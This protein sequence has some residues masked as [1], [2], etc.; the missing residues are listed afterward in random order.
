MSDD[1]ALERLSK[2]INTPEGTGEVLRSEVSNR[3]PSAPREWGAPPTGASVKKRFRIT[4][5]EVVFGGSVVFFVGA[6]VFAFLL[7]F[8]GNNTV[9]TKNVDIAVSGPTEIGAGNTLDLQVVIT[10]RNTV[11][12]ELPDLIVEFPAGTRSDADV[13]V[14]LPRVRK[15]LSTIEPGQSVHETVRAVLFG[16]EGSEAIVK[17][18]VEYRVPA[19]NAIFFA[20]ATYSALI[21]QAPASIT[22]SGFGPGCV[23]YG[24]GEFKRSRGSFEHV[25]ASRISTGFFL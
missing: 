3:V 22:V 18:S 23:V 12:M 19:S 20:E 14:E 16:Q 7:L 25:A 21:N 9:S 13:S 4:L 10:N 17:A 6:V 5:L 2:K 11:P 24:S 8:S 1:G 15:S